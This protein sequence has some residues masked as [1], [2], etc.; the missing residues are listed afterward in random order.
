[1]MHKIAKIIKLQTSILLIYGKIQEKT[2]Q[3]ATRRQITSILFSQSTD[4]T[5]EQQ[6]QANVQTL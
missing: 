3:I 5:E 4:I 6:I 2:R 1:M